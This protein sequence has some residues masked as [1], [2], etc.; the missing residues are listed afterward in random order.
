MKRNFT[1]LITMALM[2]LAMLATT[3]TMWGQNRTTE[4]V[5]TLDGT[6]TGGSNGYATE[7][8][9]TQS[10]IAWKVMGNT[11]TNPW[12]IGGKNLDSV[13]R[14]IYSQTA[15][16][17]NVCQ[18]SIKHGSASSITVNS[19]TVSIH[20]TAANA[21][22]GTNA[23]ASFTP[24][25]ADN[26]S[27]IITK[28]NST[29]WANCFYRIVYN[30]SVSGNTNRYIQ[31]INARL[32][33]EGSSTTPSIT[34]SNVNIAYNANAG[35]IAY[36]LNNAT[37]H[38]TASVPSGSWLTLGTV[39][40]TAV[41]F[42]CGTNPTASARTT[43]VTLSFTGAADKVVTVTQAGNPNIVD[44]IED[45]SGVGNYTIV[46]TIVAKS[47][48][49]FIVGDGTGYVY[50]Y[51]TS[52]TP[53][54]YSI[55]DMVRLAGPV[56]AYG[57]VYEFN[58]STVVTAAST[59]NYVAEDPTVLSGADMDGRVAS[60][61]TTL[62]NYVQY[63]GKLSVSGTY[64]N[65]TNID[66][67]TTAK[68]SISYP[69]STE[70]TSLNN[71]VVTVTGYFVGVSSSQYYNTMI[72]SIEEVVTSVATPQFTPVA[73]TY[74][75]GKSV[76]ISC[77][78]AGSEIYY[79]TDGSAPTNASTHY[80][81]AINVTAT[82]TIKAIAYV[83][84]AY[85][86]VATATYHINSEENPY[87][88]AQALDFDEYPTSP[89][90]VHGI[91]S[92]APT[93]I[94]SGKLSYYISDDGSTTTQL[95]VYKGKNLDDTSFTSVDD[96][97][98]GDTVTIYGNVKIFNNTIYEFDEGNYLVYWARPV[99]PTPTITVETL[100][101]LDASEHQGTLD[102]TYTLI[103]T[104]LTPEVHW[105]EAD[106]TTPA[107]EPEWADVE[108]NS[109]LDVDYLVGENTGAART[110]YFKVYGLDGDMHDVYSNLVTISQAAGSTPPTPPS[111]TYWRL[112]PFANLT[113]DDVFVVVGTTSSDATYALPNDNGAT[114]APYVVPVTIVND[115]LLY[116]TVNDKSTGPIG[117][118]IQWNLGGN[119]TDGYI[120]YPNGID[121]TWLFCNTTAGSSNNNN[122][123]VGNDTTR[124]R[125]ILNSD[126]QIITKDTY[127]TRY[128][129]VYQSQDWR[130]YTSSTT[131]ATTISFFRKIGSTTEQT[132]TLASSIEVPAAGET[133]TIAVTYKN[134]TDIVADVQFYESDG[135]TE[136]SQPSWITNIDL[137]SYNNVTYT[138][139][140]ND[141]PDVRTAYFKV[142]ALAETRD[143][144]V[145]SNLV[146]ITQ[147]A[148]STGTF[149]VIF[150]VGEGTFVANGDFESANV[151]KEAG[152]YS[153]PSAIRNNYVFT[154][155]NDGTSTYESCDDYE[156][157]ANVTFNAQWSSDTIGM[158]TF[159]NN[160]LKINTDSVSGPDTYGHTWTIKTAGTSSFT[161]SSDY[162]QVGSGSSAADSITFTMTLCPQTVF[163]S[164]SAKFG[165]NSGTA[166]NVTLKVDDTVVGSGSLHS[167]TIDTINSTVIISGSTLT[168]TVKNIAK[169]V[170]CYYIAYSVNSSTDPIINAP[171]EIN[172]GSTDTDNEFA[173][174]LI[175]PM[176]GEELTATST[177][178]WISN[179][180]VTAEKVTF[181]TTVNTSTTE[182]RHGE[183]ILSY[184]TEN[185]TVVVNQSKV[186]YAEM[187]FIFV[188]NES[189]T[190]TGVTLN[191]GTYSSSPYLKFDATGKMLVLK[192]LEAP[193]SVSYD[194][195]GNGFSGGQFDVEYSSDGVTYNTLQHYT[196][197]AA[198]TVS[199]TH[200]DLLPEVRFIR[201]IYTSKSS[202]NVALGNIIAD[203]N[204]LIY[205]DVTTADMTVTSTK[206]CKVYN[207]GKLTITNA[208]VNTGN[209]T[210]NVIVEDGGQLITNSAVPATVRKSIVASNEWGT[211]E[212]ATD[213]WYTLSLPMGTT[214]AAVNVQNMITTGEHN[215]YDLYQ[216]DENLQG[217]LNYKE[218]NLQ[219]GFPLV[220]G[221]GYLYASETAKTLSFT[222]TLRV[223][224]VDCSLTRT[225]HLN[226][227]LAGWNLIGNP[228]THNIYKG[229][230]GAIN[231]DK[232]AEG[233]F[234]LTDD[235]AWGAELGYDT[236]IKPCQSVLVE[237][238][239][240]VDVTINK[241][242]ASATSEK[243]NHEYIAFKVA[244]SDY[245]DVTYA[246]FDKGI[247]LSKINHRNAAIPMV[248]I[249]QNGKNYAI[250]TMSDAT[251]TFNLNFKAATTG[252]YTLS[253]KTIG[254]YDYIHVIDKVTGED[255]DML[256]EGSYTFMASPNDNDSRFI[257][258]I[259]Y[260][261]NY[262]SDGEIF[263]YQ[264]GDDIM[265]TGH[266]TLK[267]FDVLGRFVM[268][269]EVNGSERLNVSALSKGV[270]VLRIEGESVKTQKI[271]IK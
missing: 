52:Y 79:T 46:G 226:L 218:G 90:Y 106:G 33:E 70:F 190:P 94:S 38:V 271:V 127:A 40:D 64:Y 95:Y 180:N 80:T 54:N 237:A 81:G 249:P 30:V 17:N 69:L 75:T 224:S 148:E 118:T 221:L 234:V 110:A 87:T 216:W 201:W 172:L 111:T 140:H 167:S 262:S 182:D 51:N 126:N 142:F 243:Y 65:I 56:I 266:G 86:M 176:V 150:N 200:I 122:I 261:P 255:V 247:G 159:G 77:T 18:I 264:S 91:V 37:G 58:S 251:E 233:F 119:S 121:T 239:E 204:Y 210:D 20:S 259:D 252:Q 53:A 44:N 141:T 108:I 177:D 139:A 73:G 187:P 174:S 267:I 123:R 13:N 116:T 146:T 151:N 83:G 36:T 186:D 104:S 102:V 93:S 43:N 42:T 185:K 134:F 63:Q 76:T 68:G 100:A 101:A 7:S 99:V 71:K 236:P 89:I 98:V 9:I 263:A 169:G 242:T 147:L 55:G 269:R 39:N 212:A 157:N 238:S 196:E 19:M 136:A 8:D 192:L 184:A 202:G 240:N 21:A 133:D 130:G 57:G 26:D 6:T 223:T 165:G 47:T 195:K 23:I 143:D 203:K 117:D 163:T 209:L 12:R 125:F 154:G 232:L 194:I 153:L 222:G 228:F 160:G 145:Y 88:V 213:G 135:T 24:T 198:S 137:N 34:A 161:Q 231:N 152:T 28:T 129:S 11:T 206:I 22:A 84:S 109:T 97:Q 214:T 183:I 173:Y 131:S 105:F 208:L 229:V 171:A 155:W 246:L 227:N 268:S 217:W 166:G 29:S 115:T 170:K 256:L 235:G 260:R 254:D 4:L 5:Y 2:L 265:L 230:G 179:I 253:V 181:N 219:S 62:T 241:I 191:M 10:S 25:F 48:R 35:S 59:S 124:K 15:I 82:T 128:L 220:P 215:D 132:I 225:E 168:V 211:D 78:T 149:S 112:T 207:G 189:E 66:G 107:T 164:V 138:I 74:A 257:V 41:P 72:G 16:S 1:V 162:S 31:F 61:D 245:E 14:T 32:Y 114:K 103:E 3:V 244:N 50:Y 193:T 258:R 178:S 199:V 120:F 156:I 175:N 248:Y 45:I 144:F 250:A 85:S 158:I 270:Y 188:G 197:L 60:S 27:V 205:G 67:A 49:G 96:I 92:T 113:S